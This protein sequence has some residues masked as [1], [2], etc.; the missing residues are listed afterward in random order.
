M[1]DLARHLTERDRDILVRLFDV[2]V[3]TTDQVQLLFLYRHRLIDRFYPPSPFGTGKPQAHWLLDEAGAV[4]VAA[5]R[6]VDRKQFGWQ[7][8]D[9]WA[10]HPQLAHRLESNRFVTDLIAATL[11][12]ERMGV[13]EWYSSRDAAKYFGGT[14]FLR[15][16]A[17]F[18]LDVP[19]GPVVCVLEWDRGTETQQVLAD[20]LDHYR[21]LDAGS[22]GDGQPLSV[23]FV[24]PSHWR[25]KML[26]R[27]LVEI[28]PKLEQRRQDRW[29]PRNDAAWPLLVAAVTD[30]REQG[31]LGRVWQSI[32]D[33][34][35]LL[36]ALP[37]L[38][39]RTNLRPGNLA[40]PLGREWRHQQ[41]G[42]WDRLSPLRRRSAATDPPPPIGEPGPDAAAEESWVWRYRQ[43]EMEQWQREAAE[44]ARRQASAHGRGGALNPGAQDGLMDDDSD[45]DG[46]GM[47][48]SWA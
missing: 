14:D 40:L 28:E 18:F 6:R 23:L 7:R 38:P 42:F 35:D 33:E 16:D 31:P 15:P 5:I 32:E 46:D 13:T 1:F 8:R 2:Q 47:E 36:R 34:R 45:D 37:E 11:P 4:L 17:M 24:V 27:A 20:K 3:L 9:D 44:R 48:E 12:N 22:R 43:A 41:P 29:Q 19:A 10:S 30:L 25:I 26:R 39:T 21:L